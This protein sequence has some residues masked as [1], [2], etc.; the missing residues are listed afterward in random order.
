MRKNKIDK[1]PDELGP[2]PA[3]EY[4]NVRS[5]GVNN[6]ENL[7]K[8]LSPETFPALKDLNVL[9]CGIELNYSSMNIFLAEILEKKANLQRFCKVTVTDAHRLEAVYLA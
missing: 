2:L 6:M 3:L 4:L 9:N 1:I 7:L 5:N 8:L